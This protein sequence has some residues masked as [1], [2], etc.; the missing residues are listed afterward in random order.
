MFLL[1]HNWNNQS[2]IL[3]KAREIVSCREEQLQ[4]ITIV[5]IDLPALGRLFSASGYVPK[6][7]WNLL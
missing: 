7:E 3:M 4:D 2:D 6:T 5:F 1:S